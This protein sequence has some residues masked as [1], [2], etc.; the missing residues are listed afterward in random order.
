M[1]YLTSI[2]GSSVTFERRGEKGLCMS[3]HE[4]RSR[5]YSFKEL[6]EMRSS[7]PSE[8]LLVV[9]RAVELL[10]DYS[11]QREWRIK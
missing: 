5:E 10:G 9:D 4:S 1:S 6:K 7:F 3:I 11:E 8:T 2:F